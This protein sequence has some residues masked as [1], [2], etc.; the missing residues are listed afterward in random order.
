MKQK[1]PL[2]MS[3]RGIS[4]KRCSLASRFAAASLLFAANCSSLQADIV[5]LKDGGVICGKVLNPQ[6]GQ[7][8]QIE[9]E[10]GSLLEFD[11]KL[12]KIRVSLERD[13]KYLDIVS[14]RGDSLEDHRAIVDQCASQQMIG[15]ANAHRERIV[16]LDPS[17]RSTWEILRYYPDEATGK[18]M[19][20]EVVMYKRGKLKGDKGRWF[21]WQEK[22]L[23]EFD[24]KVKLQKRDAEREFD[25]KLKAYLSGNGRVK[26]EAE[27]YLQALNNPLLIGRLAKL[28][29]EGRPNERA[30]CLQL[31]KQ[32]PIRSVTPAL[33]SIA[34]E[35]QD[36]QVVSEVLE[37]LQTG[38]ETVREVAV[39]SF[40]MKLANPATRDRAAYCMMPF[41]DKRFISM[42]INHL[43]ST[44]VVQPAGPPG[45]LNAGTGGGGVGFTG[46]AP[47][48]QKRLVQHKDVLTALQGLTGE[49]YGFNV[50]E[51]RRWF[52]YSYAVQNLDLR[53]DEY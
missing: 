10:D 9:T 6:S 36:T 34:I 13:S 14:K 3:H 25:G 50:E 47:A 48:A 46:G 31:L 24:E 4:A 28:F 27:A 21:T 23:L 51:W 43:L 44:Q 15:L 45:G 2:P 42:L 53:R 41:N 20:R 29:R 52:A 7:T 12:V 16:E 32:M 49:N 11:R 19:R 40:A 1:Q 33:I 30:L 37:V 8:V 17:D 26:A 39:T 35:D 22:A 18:W 38:D 5:E